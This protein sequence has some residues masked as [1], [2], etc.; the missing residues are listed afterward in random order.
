MN[1]LLT[2][3]GDKDIAT[4]NNYMTTTKNVYHSIYTSF[5]SKQNEIFVP[6]NSSNLPTKHS[7]ASF[8]MIP[9]FMRILPDEAQ[10]LIIVIDDFHNEESYLQNENI[11][12]NLSNQFPFLDIIIIDIYLT[13]E[14]LY[15][16]IQI[17]TT[18]ANSIHIQPN[19]Y[20]LC[21]FIRFRQPNSTEQELEI[22]I[23]EFTQ[24]ILNSLHD[25]KYSHSYYQWFGYSYYTSD[26]MYCYKTYNITY[27]FYAN[28]I[29]DI[30][31]NSL[32]TTLLN[33]YNII[34]V[35]YYV[36]MR[37]KRLRVIWEQFQTNSLIFVL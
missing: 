16:I 35:Q 14:L 34:D 26:Y 7:N 20:K 8:Q 37:D 21:N 17:I 13:K 30:L 32:V 2:F 9:S 5:G 3:K 36:D 23:P 22:W 6:S 4:F 33:Q 29:Y 10:G 24:N 31:R 28:T 19:N 11:L 15:S 18:F 25:G 12:I 1:S 27:M